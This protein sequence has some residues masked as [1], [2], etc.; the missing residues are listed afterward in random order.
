[1]AHASQAENIKYKLMK[2]HL[3]RKAF[4][5][6]THFGVRDYYRADF[7]IILLAVAQYKEPQ[8]YFHENMCL[9]SEADIVCDN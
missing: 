3:S 6:I 1:V 4:L 8:D 2:K 5:I 9:F 7:V